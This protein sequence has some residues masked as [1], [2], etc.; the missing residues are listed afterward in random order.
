MRILVTGSRTWDDT[1]VIRDA[2]TTA[3][4]DADPAT[5][6]LIHGGYR[7]ADTIAARTAARMG[8]TVEEHPAD[9]ARWGRRAGPIRNAEMV[10]TGADICLVF[11][12]GDSTGTANCAAAAEAAG[13]TVKRWW[14][15]AAHDPA[16][17]KG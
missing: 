9:W 13:M 2:L 3:L 15:P 14:A 10:R 17:M 7:G 4:G 12:R 11:Q 1:P 6:T 8:M 16:I 5:V